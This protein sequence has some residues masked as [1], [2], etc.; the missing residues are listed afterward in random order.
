[1]LFKD[2]KRIF[3]Y[4]KKNLTYAQDTIRYI[5]AQYR[6]KPQIKKTGNEYIKHLNISKHFLIIK[7]LLRKTVI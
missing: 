3:R 1:M 5:F 7:R 2:F 6:K 4:F